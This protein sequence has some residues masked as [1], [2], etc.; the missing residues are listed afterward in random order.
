MS[1]TGANEDAAASGDLDITEDLTI[2]GAG[3]KTTYIDGMAADRVFEVRA[4]P[5]RS[6]ASPYRMVALM[7]AEASIW[8]DPATLH[9]AT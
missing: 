4:A 9:S 2:T 6:P 5:L 3:A 7:M 1:L 8:M